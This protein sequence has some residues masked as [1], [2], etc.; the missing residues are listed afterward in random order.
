M[1]LL[2]RYFF[3]CYCYIITE[4]RLSKT[5]GPEFWQVGQSSVVTSG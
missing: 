4:L 1:A 5:L 3:A 2:S